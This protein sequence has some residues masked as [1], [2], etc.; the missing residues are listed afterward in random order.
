MPPRRDPRQ[1]VRSRPVRP[2]AKA[3]R[4]APEPGRSWLER[5]TSLPRPS[6]RTLLLAS[7]ALAGML[8]GGSLLGTVW[9]LRDRSEGLKVDVTPA[10]L[11]ALPKRSVTVL[12]IGIEAEQTGCG[13]S[14]AAP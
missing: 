7:L 11:A 10:N 13:E 12:V 1:P 8:V 14:A 4:P 2:S 5:L 6:P 3:T 9:P